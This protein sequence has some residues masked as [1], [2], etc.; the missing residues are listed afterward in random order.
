MGRRR[1]RSS[2]EAR[3]DVGVEKSSIWELL[4][5]Q[6]I[7][8]MSIHVVDVHVSMIDVFLR[9]ARCDENHTSSA[10]GG[11]NGQIHEIQY[12]HVNMSVREE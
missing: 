12:I 7:T 6:L 3:K 10:G 11:T 4:L 1:R 5:Q 9:A 8:T 2:T